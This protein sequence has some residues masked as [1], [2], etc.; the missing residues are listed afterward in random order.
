MSAAS[1]LEPRSSRLSPS[2]PS[3]TPRRFKSRD[4][5]PTNSGRRRARHHQ[6]NAD[7]QTKL[8]PA[9]ESRYLLPL[10]TART[11]PTRAAL[12]SQPAHTPPT[13]PTWRR[14]SAACLTRE[15]HP[16]WR[17]VASVVVA[18]NLRDGR[19]SRVG[20][21]ELRREKAGHTHAALVHARVRG[22][23]LVLGLLGVGLGSRRVWPRVDRGTC[24]ARAT[25]AG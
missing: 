22:P 2:A 13:R 24:D 14:R 18:C 23:G 3:S 5:A 8:S 11:V 17:A 25:R 15:A 7:N 12:I 1:L 20:L 19:F 9:A 21:G 16:T 6:S 10:G 4:V